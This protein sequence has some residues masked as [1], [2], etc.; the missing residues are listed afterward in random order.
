MLRRRPRPTRCRGIGGIHWKPLEESTTQ[1]LDRRQFLRYVGG[2]TA[3]AL[4][5]GCGTTPE[6]QS[7]ALNK[8][9]IVVI[10]ADD[11]GFS[12]IGCYGGEIETPNIDA[13]ADGG[14][15]F[16]Q[17]YNTARCC[18]TRAALLTGLYQHQA[19]VGHMMAAYSKDGEVIP[20]YQAKLNRECV[21]FGEALRPAG[22]TTLMSGKWHVTP[23][24]DRETA[25]DIDKS[26]WP[27]QR[28]F[29]RFWGTIHGAGSFYD[30]VTL[31]D[32][33]DPI[34][35]ESNDFYYTTAIAEN[36]VRLI[37][38]SPR[39]KPFF[40]YM[41]FTSPHWPLRAP[42]EDIA[43]YKGKYDMGWD[44]LRTQRHQ[45]MIEMG[46]IKKE[47]DL[48]PRDEVVVPWEEAE[49]KEWQS[50]RMEVYAAQIT[51]MDRAIGQLVGKLKQ[52]GVFDNTLIFFLADNGGCA[53][54]LY[55][56]STGLHIPKTTLDGRPV[57][58]GN[59]PQDMP[60][61]DDD[62]QSYGVPWA[63]ASN[64]PF[65]LYKHWVHEGGISS[66][67]VVQ[68]PQ[69]VTVPG[70]WTDQPGHLI[71][72]MATCLDVAGAEYPKTYEG[73]EITPLE[74]ESLRPIFSGQDRNGHADGIFWEHE[75]N[76]AM[77]VGKWKLVSK[78]TANGI[79]GRPIGEPIDNQWELYD[80][81]ADRTEM[82]DLAAAMPE[83]T[84]ELAQI[85]Q[86]W[87]DRAGGVEWRSWDGG[88]ARSSVPPKG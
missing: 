86:A 53:E 34:K 41:P 9:N 70:T 79:R 32:E 87:A 11:M 82:H 85:W 74:G 10:M 1:N 22:Y 28:G 76:R 40:L 45:R 48:T 2:A 42:D 18:P 61:Q 46:V 44:E 39:D 13:L 66:P 65:R 71:D 15:R 29:D 23:S 25:T 17:F 88:E 80:I 78:W 27:R 56:D 20:A 7:T 16:R 8:P 19:G 60:G 21:T 51:V 37:D 59:D 64:T 84:Q 3:A 52:L 72:I 57:K 6:R 33:N 83:K 81:D 4:P 47:W 62:Y 5:L 31:T 75:G 55:P 26:N 54:E 14:L 30:P 43:R 12:D 73:H 49:N 63:N 50:R 38:E 24:V 36:A 69:G 58:L 77:R 67:L 68:W 35:P